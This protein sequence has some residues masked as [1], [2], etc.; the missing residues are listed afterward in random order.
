MNDSYYHDLL[1]RLRWRGAGP[2]DEIPT[3]IQ[4]RVALVGFA[5]SGKKTLF[6][7]FWAWQAVDKNGASV[8]NFGLFSLIDLP[9]DDYDAAGV[10][11]RL[12]H[13]DLIIYLLDGDVKPDDFAWIARLRAL[14]ATLL[15]VLN[16]IDSW[17]PDNVAER[18]AKLQEGLAR[19]V[20]ALSAQNSADVHQRLLPMMLKLCPQLAVPLA[21]ELPALRHAVAAHLIRQTTLASLLLCAER[22]QDARRSFS[23]RFRIFGDAV[24]GQPLPSPTG[25][26]A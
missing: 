20:L 12:E 22:R 5:G 13:A 8:R 1:E 24:Q 7:N 10:L 11:Y 3:P 17:H 21:S 4:G 14:N 19:P 9:H 16:K 6:N 18:V 15:V 23:G 26:R 25:G 2:D